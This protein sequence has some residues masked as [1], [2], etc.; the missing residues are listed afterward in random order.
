MRFAWHLLRGSRG[1]PEN[2]RYRSIFTVQD[3]NTAY[4]YSLIVGNT[5][6][7]LSFGFR[8]GSRDA[9]SYYVPEG[10]EDAVFGYGVT[11]NIRLTWNGKVAVMYLNDQAK[12][13]VAYAKATASWSTVSTLTIG[14]NNAPP[15]G[16][17]N[18]S[19]DII[20]NFT[21]YS[22]SA[23][24]PPTTSDKSAPTVPSNLTARAVSSSQVDL[25]W[26]AAT[27][28]VG[29]SGYHVYRNKTLI[30]TV[31]GTGHSDTSVTAS[32]IYSYQVAAFDAAGNSSALSTVVTIST[33]S[34][35]S[36]GTGNAK[37]EG[38]LFPVES[39][40]SLSGWARDPDSLTQ[41]VK[42][43][44][45]IDR[46]PGQTGATPVQIT[47]SLTRADVGSHGFA[48]TIPDAY[49]DGKPHTV[50]VWAA[51]LTVTTGAND[52]QISGS[53]QTFTLGAPGPTTQPPPPGALSS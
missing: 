4:L 28:N 14:A 1:V 12:A 52:A 13:T 33:S 45:Y 34:S 8:L 11:A 38:L 21:V 20:S 25:S 6:G 46:A 10:Q 2:G 17:Y 30:A 35:S 41:F 48:Y 49:R 44:I 9:I 37:P 18:S 3:S 16:V 29:V 24:P 23:V 5:A 22:S 53:P 50:W 15:L 27:D 32:N 40:G 51:D 47:A 31:L 26:S 19:D 36:S 43:R 7:R 42:V 39:T